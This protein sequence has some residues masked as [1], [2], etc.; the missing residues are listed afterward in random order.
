[1]RIPWKIKFAFASFFPRVYYLINNFPHRA[2]SQRFWDYFLI[3]NWENPKFDWPTKNELIGTYFK[4]NHRIVDIGFGTGTLLK[5][6]K[7]KGL[8]SLYGYEHSDFA[9]QQISKLNIIPV[10][11]SLPKLNLE[12]NKYDGVIASEVLEHLLRRKRFL[13]EMKRV[14]KP[15]GLGIITVPDDCMGPEEIDEH[16]FKYTKK[17]LKKL[18]SAYFVVL[19][20]YTIHDK[21]HEDESIIAV[22]KK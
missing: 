12:S 10:K 14:L 8:T 1:M 7:K 22:V 17:S 4:K 6:L 9:L 20:V 21:N 19:T 5:F 15:D 16:S 13:K 2:N 3:E 18:L 11:G